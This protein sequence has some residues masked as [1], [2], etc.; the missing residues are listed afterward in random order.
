[1]ELQ[2]SFE[3]WVKGYLHTE[4][5]Q[6]NTT[7]TLHMSLGVCFSISPSYSSLQASNFIIFRAGQ[8]GLG[9]LTFKGAPRPSCRGTK[10][11]AN[12]VIFVHF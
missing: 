3:P 8:L 2:I 4:N 6:P 10:A 9:Y 5:L 11:K 7:P 12:F 1:M